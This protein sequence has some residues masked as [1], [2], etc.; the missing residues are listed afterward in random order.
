MLIKQRKNDD[1]MSQVPHKNKDACHQN[2]SFRDA[3]TGRAL[4]CVYG[5]GLPIN[6]NAWF[7][8]KLKFPTLHVYVVIYCKN[9][10]L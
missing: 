9:S 10:S 6:V 3:P 5:S 2:I 1:T 8:S 4:E 7:V